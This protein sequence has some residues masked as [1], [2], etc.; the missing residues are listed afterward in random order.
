MSKAD[1]KLS[2]AIDL[3]TLGITSINKKGVVNPRDRDNLY[4]F[5]L[6]DRDRLSMDFTAAKGAGYEIYSVKRSWSK[7]PKGISSL[8]FRQLRGGKLGGNLQRVNPGELDA[9][10]YII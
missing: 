9:G 6:G 8:D 1:N 7:I 4:R 10:D 3:G 2:G 5:T